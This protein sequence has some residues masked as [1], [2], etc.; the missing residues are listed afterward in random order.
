MLTGS[1]A[2]RT[3]DQHTLGIVTQAQTGHGYSG[4]YCIQNINKPTDFP[5]GAELQT[6]EHILF[7]CEIHEELWHVIDKGNPDHK[8]VM[9]LGTKMGIDALAKF[10]KGT[11]AFQ[12]PK[13]QDTL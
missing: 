12:K 9:L 3:L 4:D 8:L 1:H 6:C 10:I 5:C 11:K 13:A 2:F 7:E